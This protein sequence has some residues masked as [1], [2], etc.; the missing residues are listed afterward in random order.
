MKRIFALILCIASLLAICTSA[1]SC[2]EYAGI[3]LGTTL[4]P[5]LQTS[6]ATSSNTSK[7]EISPT[8]AAPS[9]TTLS[10]TDVSQRLPSPQN[11]IEIDYFDF[12]GD[13]NK[14]AERDSGGNLIYTAFSDREMILKDKKWLYPFPLYNETSGYNK[15]LEYAFT[16]NGEVLKLTATDENNP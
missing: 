12:R 14:W 13:M 16:E 8:S 9:A 2:S 6:E 15:G 3:T 5:S 10:T 1:A 7:P 11:I 4:A